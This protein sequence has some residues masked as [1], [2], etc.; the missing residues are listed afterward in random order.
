MQ[1][2]KAMYLDDDDEHDDDDDEEENED[3]E[4]EEVDEDDEEDDEELS[5][6]SVSATA[7]I[8][9]MT[10]QYYSTRQQGAVISGTHTQSPG[11]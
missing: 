8:M 9:Q 3:E 5:N 11:Q 4:D 1:I 10:N 7:R 6:V 2:Y